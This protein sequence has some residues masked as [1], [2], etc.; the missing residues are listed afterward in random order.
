MNTFGGDW[1]EIKIEI[2]TEYAEA[3]LKIMKVHAA[4]NK[5]KLLYFDGFAGSGFIKKGKEENQRLIVGAARRI[6]EIESPRAFDLYYFVENDKKNEEL[7]RENTEKLFP[8]KNIHVVNTDCNEKIMAMSEFLSGTNGKC[9]KALAY[10]D[11]C[12]MQL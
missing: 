6:L 7:L 10:I 4:R 11:P 8:H 5:W 3:Y 2:L 1:T 12:G 9:Y